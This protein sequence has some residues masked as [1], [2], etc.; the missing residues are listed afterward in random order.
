MASIKYKK[1]IE[2]LSQLDFTES[3]RAGHRVFTH[4]SKNTLVVLPVAKLS[5]AVPASRLA[6]IRLSIIGANIASQTEIDMMLSG[7][8]PQAA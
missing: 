2:I 6:A 8:K 7:R 3:K 5:E 1:L 4:K